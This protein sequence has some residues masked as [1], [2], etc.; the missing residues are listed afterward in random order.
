MNRNS[1]HFLL[2]GGT[3]TFIFIILKMIANYCSENSS[4]DDNN[5]YLS[6]ENPKYGTGIIKIDRKRNQSIKRTKNY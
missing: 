6:T 5:P 4:I 1:K 2:A 3:A